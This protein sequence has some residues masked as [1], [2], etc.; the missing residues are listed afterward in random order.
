VKRVQAA[1][2]VS[3]LALKADVQTD[4][5]LPFDPRVVGMARWIAAA[6]AV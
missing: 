5:L 4:H 2:I 1:V 3:L 6:I